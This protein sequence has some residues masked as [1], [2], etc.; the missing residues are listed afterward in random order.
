[1]DFVGA[2]QAGFKNYTN[3]RGVAKRPAYWY[4]I[5]FTVLA[6]ITASA[7]DLLT[8]A[9]V[10]GAL[11]SFGTFLP[12]LAISV[13]RLRDAGKSWLWLLSPLPGVIMSFVGLFIVAVNLY[14]FGYVTTS[15]QLN[16]P[17]FPSEELISQV[18]ADSRFYQGF[19]LII[20]GI[21]IAFVFSVISSIIFMAQPSK[22]FADGNKRVPPTF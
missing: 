21:A 13:R 1:M 20:A 2:I 12:N 9:S 3:F 16:D 11:V 15:R 10:F 22:S 4:W 8:H 17:N 18:I 6:S 7:L 14:D 19:A 5:L